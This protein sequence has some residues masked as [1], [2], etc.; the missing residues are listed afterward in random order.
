MLADSLR[1]RVERVAELNRTLADQP[2]SKKAGDWIA[3]IAEK[4]LNRR[5]ERHL[6]VVG[7]VRRL[8]REIARIE[9]M[10]I[11]KGDLKELGTRM[12]RLRSRVEKDGDTS[13]GRHAAKLTQLAH[14]IEGGGDYARHKAR[15]PKLRR[16][17]EDLLRSG[18]VIYKEDLFDG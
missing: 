13:A 1:A 14:R 6:A 12:D 18:D 10:P 5:E 7:A 17:L 16:K 11:E 8:R 2:N 3:E 9:A 15:V 4:S